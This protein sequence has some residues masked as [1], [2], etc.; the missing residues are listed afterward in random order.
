MVDTVEDGSI[1]FD[2]GIKQ[3]N[4]RYTHLIVKL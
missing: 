4:A 3:G 1:S 2:S